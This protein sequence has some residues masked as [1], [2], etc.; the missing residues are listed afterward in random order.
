MH[1]RT[2]Q[3]PVILI[4]SIVFHPVLF[5]TS[6]VI[7]FKFDRAYVAAEERALSSDLFPVVASCCLA[8]RAAFLRKLS[9]CLLIS[10]LAIGCRDSDVFSELF[11]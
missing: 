8:D 11:F 7:F 9:Y 3:L 10:N 1:S 2:R 6:L 5:Y 4:S